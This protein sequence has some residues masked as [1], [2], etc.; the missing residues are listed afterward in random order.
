MKSETL[1]LGLPWTPLDQAWVAFLQDRMPSPDPLHAHLAALVSHQMGRGHACLDLLALWQDPLT[2]LGWSKLVWPL[3]GLPPSADNPW[4]QAALS[5]PWVQGPGSPMVLTMDAAGVPRRLYLRRAWAA[6]QAILKSIAD[7]LLAPRP[8]PQ[9]LAD[10]L[11]VLFPPSGDEVDWQKTACALAARE[12]MTLITGGPGTGKTTTVVR[13]LALLQREASVLGQAPLRIHLAA[14]TGK[15]A[16]RL[17]QSIQNALASLPAGYEQGIPVQAVTLHQL[18]QYM[19]DAPLRAFEPLA[20]DLV[21]VDEASMIDLELMARLMGMVPVS[22]R[23]VLLGDKDQLASVEAGA[24]WSQLCSGAD[25]FSYSAQTLEWLQQRTRQDFTPWVRSAKPD[26][27]ALAQQT[28]M[29]RRSRRFQAHSDIGQWALAVNAGDSAA[30]QGLWQNCIQLPITPESARAGWTTWLAHLAPM[31][32]PGAVCTDALALSLMQAF[33]EFQVLCALRHGPWGVE[34]I[35]QQLSRALGFTQATT[36][37]QEAWFVGRPVMLTRNDYQLKLMNGDVGQCLPT[38]QGLRVAFADGQG[39][40]RWVLPSRLEEVETVWAMT[41]HKSQGSEYEHVLM[42]LP[43][44]PSPVLTR[45][46]LYTGITRAKNK[47][48]WWLPSQSVLYQAVQQQVWRSGG[49]SDALK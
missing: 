42:V 46:L 38:A 16:S 47:L 44:R 23:L 1:R 49:L 15:A 11:H 2:L 31:R 33:A 48:S 6:E 36:Q 28:V 34:A 13:L 40:V 32:Q 35:N 9:N 27:G 39:G 8:E 20:S 25:Q 26:A 41:V 10:M 17:S 43:D 7:R 18:L 45:E 24:V 5:L 12:G 22:A 4:P 37:H 21:V 3:L 14:P 19:P 30:A 29:L